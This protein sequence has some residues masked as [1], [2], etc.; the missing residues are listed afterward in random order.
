MSGTVPGTVS[1]RIAT[2]GDEDFILALNGA[3]APGVA[4]MTADDYRRLRSWA[5]RVLVAELDGKPVGFLILIEPGTA[6]PSD[7]YGWFE[8]RFRRHLYVDRIAVD[9]SVKRKGI[10][11][12]M[13]DAAAL[14]AREL[15][16]PRITCEV[17]EDPPNPESMAFHK[18]AGLHHV[19][20]RPSPRLGKVVAMFV[21]ELGPPK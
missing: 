13:Y 7:N 20:S 5:A 11:R 10:G 6:Y 15:D 19:A 2:D 17:N 12:A 8:D 21:R 14:A 9:P 4:E 1:V 18:A 16:E 3:S